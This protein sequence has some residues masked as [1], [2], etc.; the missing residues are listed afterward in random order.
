MAAIFD[1]RHTQTSDSIPF[2][3]SV[4]PDPE[5]IGNA[6]GIALLSCLKAE[7]YVISYLPLVLSRQIGYLAGAPLVLTPPTCS[8][9]ISSK[10][11]K[12]FRLFLAV[13]KWQQQ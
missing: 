12:R 1:F 4:L 13:T 6:V 5:N 2:S 7:I 10:S 8:P 11:P 3:L 9:T